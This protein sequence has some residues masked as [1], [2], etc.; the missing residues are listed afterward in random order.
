MPCWAKRCLADDEVSYCRNTETAIAGGFAWYINQAGCTKDEAKCS[1][2]GRWQKLCLN[3]MKRRVKGGAATHAK[4]YVGDVVGTGSSR[5]SATNSVVRF[6]RKRA[7]TPLDVQPL[8]VCRCCDGEKLDTINHEREKLDTIIM[9]D[10]RA[11]IHAL[12]QRLSL[13]QPNPMMLVASINAAESSVSAALSLADENALQAYSEIGFRLINLYRRRPHDP[14]LQDVLTARD[15]VKM[16]VGADGNELPTTKGQW[17]H[18]MGSQLMAAMVKLPQVSGKNLYR[19]V[20]IRSMYISQAIGH[21]LIYEAGFLSTSTEKPMKCNGLI[22]FP[23]NEVN[24]SGAD[25]SSQSKWSTECEVLFPPATYQKILEMYE[26]EDLDFAQKCAESRLPKL[27]FAK[28]LH[29]F[30]DLVRKVTPLGFD[31]EGIEKI[32]IASLEF[33]A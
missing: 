13:Y 15:G 7:G 20:D 18:M 3:D 14:E 24:I 16:F 19:G 4:T 29:S 1:L 27:R 31:A 2:P 25:I 11:E 32:L 6:N 17:A 22:I 21:G 23:K 10:Q 30:A 9:D 33:V 26:I 8:K 28:D 12:K 5:K